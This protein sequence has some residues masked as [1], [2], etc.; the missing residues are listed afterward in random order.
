[1]LT[2]SPVFE[3][4]YKKYLEQVAG[5]EFKSLEEQLK[6]FFKELPFGQ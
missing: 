6:G 3:E 2:R 1:M 4:T 5:I